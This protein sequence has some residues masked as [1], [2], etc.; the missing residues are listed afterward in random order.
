MILDVVVVGGDDVEVVGVGF[1]IGVVGGVVVVGFDLLGVV[2]FELV[3]EDNVGGLDVVEGGVFD[4][5]IVG[6]DGD[7][8]GVV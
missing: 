6:V 2:V 3:V 5:E 8:D 7:V 1:E 4:G